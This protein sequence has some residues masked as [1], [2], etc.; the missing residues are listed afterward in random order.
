MS[1]HLLCTHN[2]HPLLQDI[3]HH[4]AEAWINH[5]V[6]Q[7]FPS[8]PPTPQA[9]AVELQGLKPGASHIWIIR[10]EKSDLLFMFFVILEKA[11][12]FDLRL[13]KSKTF[14]CYCKTVVCYMI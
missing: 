1:F 8:F 2:H 4:S 14:C 6:A 13:R 9:L 11:G 7:T 10:L 3:T 12:L 5:D